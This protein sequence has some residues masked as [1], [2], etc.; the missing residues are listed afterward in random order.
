VVYAP[1]TV[2]GLDFRHL[3]HEQGVQQ[4]IQLL[5]H[6]HADTTNGKLYCN[7]ID[8]YQVHP[9]IPYPILQDTRLLNWC[10]NGWLTSIRA[11]LHSTNTQVI[12]EDPWIPLPR[13]QH[14]RNIMD[15]L[16]NHLPQANLSAINNVRLYLKVTYLS[17]ITD[18]SGQVLLPEITQQWHGNPQSTLWWPYQPQ[19]T[20]DAW[21]QWSYAIHTLYTWP[22]SDRL[23]QPLAQWLPTMVNRQW[24][25]EW[26][27]N[28]HTRALY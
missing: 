3:G 6:L 8:A 22:S 12:M 1:E 9:C 7:L 26:R 4:V 5:K 18:A 24:Q 28:P 17:K 25:W 15:N 23:Q 19:P 2:G 21:K 16:L 13:H 11:F 10:P 14:D 20:P 27:I